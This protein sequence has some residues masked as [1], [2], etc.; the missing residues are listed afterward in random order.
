MALTMEIVNR[1]ALPEGTPPYH[2]SSNRN[3]VIGRAPGLDWTLPDETRHVS[4]RHCGIRFDNG[5]YWLHDLSTNGVFVNGSR[6]R[7]AAPHRLSDGDRIAIGR[8]LV[9]VRIGE[10]AEPSIPPAPR[11]PG[12]AGDGDRFLALVCRGAGMAP[13]SLSERERDALALEIGTCLRLMADNVGD[14]LRRR[15]SA[16]ALTRSASRTVIGPSGNNPLKFLA[17]SSEALETMFSR[18]RKGYLDAKA[19]IEDA[20]AD[21]KSHEMATFAAMQQALGRL[22][23]DF[24]PDT[25]E[26]K[27]ASSVFASRKAR[28]WDLFVERWEERSAGDNG[29]LDAFLGYFAEA[30]DEAVEQ[31]KAGRS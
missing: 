31:E 11:S 9:E 22:L 18:R 15:A 16:K 3:V 13:E 7:L 20:F 10:P 19:S 29:M 30:Y 5:T 17:T 24:S 28:A 14:L 25:I 12:A 21:L 26:H 23:D 8:Y 2:R 27:A 4:A 1:D 6:E